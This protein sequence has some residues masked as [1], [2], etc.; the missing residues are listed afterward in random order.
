M[1]IKS[2]SKYTETTRALKLA[3]KSGLERIDT[4][5]FGKNGVITHVASDDGQTII[6]LDKPVK[7]ITKSSDKAK[8]SKEGGK[9]RKIRPYKG[10]VGLLGDREDDLSDGQIKQTALEQGYVPKSA[11]TAPGNAGSMANEIL[12][13]E[14][15]NI[16]Q[17]KPDMSDEDLIS[18]LYNQT[19]NT[20]LGKQIA[21]KGKIATKRSKTTP[22][23]L[24]NQLYS[25][26]KASALSGKQKYNR[27]AKAINT[28]SESGKVSKPMKIRNYY[29]TS[30]SLQKQIELIEQ[31]EGPFYTNNGVEIP[32]EKLIFF[33]KNS[34]GGDNPCDTSTIALDEKGRGIVTFHS[35]KMTT[36]DILSNTTPNS[37][38]SRQMEMINNLKVDNKIKEASNNI[39]NQSIQ[40][41]NKIEAAF[42][43]AAIPVAEQLKDKDISEIIKAIKS[44]EDIASRFV[45]GKKSVFQGVKGKYK[46]PTD[47]S[48]EAS[49]EEQLQAFFDYMAS[50]EKSKA[51]S[52]DMIKFISRIAKS[53]GIK[54]DFSKIRKQAIERQQKLLEDLNSQ[55]ITIQGQKMGLGNYLE[56]KILFKN[57]H[58]DIIDG[59]DASNEIFRFSGLLNVN[60]G[61]VVV[62]ANELRKS[63]GVSS[64]DE[65]MMKVKIGLP[66]TGQT[67]TKSKEGVITGRNIF[68]YLLDEE[69]NKVPFAYKT[70]RSKQGETGRTN[71]TIQYTKEMQE[72]LVENSIKETK[73]FKELTLDEELEEI[74]GKLPFEIDITPWKMKHKGNPKG[75]DTWRFDYAISTH[76]SPAIGI[77]DQDV[78]TFKGAYKKAIKALVDYFKRMKGRMK[79]AR[80]K[81]LP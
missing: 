78:F 4:G 23:G 69:G 52:K 45:G 39:I 75:N 55:K 20:K 61:G 72:R 21:S 25:V 31:S 2:F 51:P 56:K 30:I 74:F 15:T 27:M 50:D 57:L 63:L 19:K 64:T 40:D 22:E 76:P 43:D 11:H 73:S 67:V 42:D 58:L 79:H 24:N 29:G 34:G 7:D 26:M 49:E 77:L 37:E 38:A 66:G 62:E 59:E 12:S 47:I 17:S 6:K 81:L 1:S 14:V 70:Q 80:V 16:L 10:G 71:N 35:D 68:L 60:H 18:V 28:L 9:Q 13:G 8:K 3:K 65:L 48:P 33:I 44:N 36:G 41:L 53:Q 5:K 54:T 32:K 46:F